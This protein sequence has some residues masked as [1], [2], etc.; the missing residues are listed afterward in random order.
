MYTGILMYFDDEVD[1]TATEI[2]ID[3]LTLMTRLGGA[4]GVGKEVLW[5]ILMITDLWIVFCH[6]AFNILS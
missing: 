4:T 3:G 5:F 1:V 2:T 6:Q